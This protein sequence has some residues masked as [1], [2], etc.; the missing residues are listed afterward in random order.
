MKI[1][2]VIKSLFDGVSSNKIGKLNIFFWLL[3]IFQTEVYAQ[4]SMVVNNLRILTHEEFKSLGETNLT[5]V[6]KRPVI[7]KFHHKSGGKLFYYGSSHTYNPND[8]ML[9]DIEKQFTGF[10]PDIVF[11]E[12]GNPNKKNELPKLLE[13]IVREKG[14]AGFVRYLARE[15][16]IPDK[17]LEPSPFAVIAELRKKFT[18]SEI[19]IH[20]ILTQTEQA[21][22]MGKSDVELDSIVVVGIKKAKLAGFKEIPE[23]I[24]QFSVEVHK[25]ITQVENWHQVVLDM[26][27]PKSLEDSLATRLQRM[28]TESSVIR[29]RHM[30]TM[31]L[32]EVAKGKR[33]FAVVG[34]SHV[35]MQ[36]PGL[37]E[38]FNKRYKN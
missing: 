25:L 5:K 17:T 23:D 24:I 38:F 4:D 31:L 8:P 19:F 21:K 27:A 35:I 22:R 33:V 29:D 30:L 37:C 9:K 26:V 20:G 14:E 3:I 32:T 6:N 18:D 10:R 34:A 15:N 2:I 7:M 12:G 16:A 1:H 36:E 28:S 11:W 13:T